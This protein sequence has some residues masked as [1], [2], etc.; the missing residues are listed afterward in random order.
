MSHPESGTAARLK[1]HSAPQMES[2]MTHNVAGSGRRVRPGILS[3]AAREFTI[4]SIGFGL[5]A[6][7]LSAQVME[8]KGKGGSR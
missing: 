2:G 5:L 6:C 1:T 4:G 3:D 7:I 8:R